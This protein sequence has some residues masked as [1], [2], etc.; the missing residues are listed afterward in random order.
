[1]ARVELPWRLAG[2]DVVLSICT[3]G[4]RSEF[5][6]DGHKSNQS[7]P[8]GL[9]TRAKHTT[10]KSFPRALGEQVTAAT[11]A[12]PR[13][14]VIKPSCQRGGFASSTLAARP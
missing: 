3:S 5:R 2:H 13:R 9:G 8:A 6:R 1:M 10:P 11:S 12:T 4:R 7:S 14:R